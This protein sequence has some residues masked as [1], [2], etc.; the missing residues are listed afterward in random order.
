MKLIVSI[1]HFSFEK[2]ALEVQDGIKSI[3]DL[4]N[5]IEDNP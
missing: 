3:K 2:E 1:N 5:S 4:K